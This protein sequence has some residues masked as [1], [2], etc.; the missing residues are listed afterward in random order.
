MP[1]V[2]K[3][4]RCPRS[5]AGRRCALGARSLNI[6]GPG[7]PPKETYGPRRQR[8]SPAASHP[9]QGRLDRV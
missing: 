5:F 3:P 9:R 1:A 8:I 4:S 6:Q 2:L 7:S